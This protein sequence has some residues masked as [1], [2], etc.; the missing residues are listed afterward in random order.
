MRVANAGGY[1]L[2]GAAAVGRAE[3]ETL[4]DGIAVGVFRPGPRPGKIHGGVGT[5]EVNLLAGHA[6]LIGAGDDGPLLGERKGLVPDDYIVLAG[7][8]LT[9]VERA[10]EQDLGTAEIAGSE[11]VADVVERPV[12]AGSVAMQHRQLS[13]AVVEDA[14]QARMAAIPLLAVAQLGMADLRQGR[15]GALHCHSSL[16]L[17]ADGP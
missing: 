5:G 15:D 2:P 6:R 7:P 1:R 9:M 11:R 16:R 8:G 14:A 12:A 4:L 17:T 13:A 3:D 10:L